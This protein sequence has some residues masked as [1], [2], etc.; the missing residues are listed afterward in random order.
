M[1][2]F[3]ALTTS[4]AG[5]RAQSFALE[6]ISGNI[7]NSQTTAF[8]RIDTSFVDLIPRAGTLASARRQRDRVFAR[9]QPPCRAT[10]RRPRSAPSWRSTAK[11]SSS[12]RSP[13]SFADGK[14]VFAGIDLYTRRGDFSHNK[15]GY[16][17]NGAGYYLM[18][19]PIDPMTGNLVGSVPEL[20]QVPERFLAGAGNERGGLSC[21]PRQLPADPTHNSAIRPCSIRIDFSANPLAVPP[22][23]DTIRFR[24]ARL[25]PDVPAIVTGTGAARR[26][27]HGQCRHVYGERRNGHFTPA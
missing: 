3:G 10:S 18:G 5:L 9:D 1:G 17:V 12:C 6:N 14:P 8:K 24:S 4:V 23:P 7:A 16:L 13:S 2:I 20:L 26:H 21:E 22:Q 25:Q 11:A 15:D 19:I 27:R